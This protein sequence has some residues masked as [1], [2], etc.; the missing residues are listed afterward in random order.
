MSENSCI[1]NIEIGKFYFIHDGSKTDHPGY[2]V[3]KDDFANRYLV[4]R[5]DSDKPRAITKEEKGEKL[6]AAPTGI[7]LET[8]ELILD[9]GKPTLKILGYYDGFDKAAVEAMPFSADLQRNQAA[10]GSGWD[11]VAFGEGKVK[12]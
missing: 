7:T 4:I 3:W 8:Q 2:V 1:K 5:T 10:G 6:D 11:K 9:E 12:I